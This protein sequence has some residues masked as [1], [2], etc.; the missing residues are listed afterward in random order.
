MTVNKSNVIGKQ[1]SANI[2][3]AA[4]SCSLY[5]D[6]LTDAQTHLVRSYNVLK[7]RLN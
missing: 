6:W 7:Q 4:H 3:V 5:Y 1:K 2:S